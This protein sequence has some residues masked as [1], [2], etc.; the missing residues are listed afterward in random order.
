[1]WAAIWRSG[2]GGTA[3][4]WKTQLAAGMKKHL[5]LTDGKKAYNPF[6]ASLGIAQRPKA[7]SHKMAERW[8][9]LSPVRN[10]EFGTTEI[11]RKIQ[12]KYRGGML[13]HSKG[14][15]IK[16]FGEQEIV[17]TDK[18]MQTVNC[19]KTAWP[20]GTTGWITSPMARS[21]WSCGRTKRNDRSDLDVVSSR[22]SRMSS[23][24]YFRWPMVD[25]QPRTGL[26]PD[27]PQVAG[28]RLRHRFPDPAAAGS[29][30]F[31]GIAL[32][33]PDP[34]PQKMVLLIER[35][36]TVLEELRNPQ[37]FRHAAAEHEYVR[38]G[39]AARSRWTA[40]TPHT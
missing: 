15:G 31:T 32:H 29:D 39:G 26:R 18:V 16:P 23:Y 22:R 21:A 27:R 20:E 33:R 2:S 9:I 36:T 3:A 35:D 13:N 19:R 4:N 25:G 8:Q 30:A 28:E 5:G 34:V 1:M 37:L 17:W 14:T 11:N 7:T 10:H 40:T 12:A 38:A 6:N 24:R